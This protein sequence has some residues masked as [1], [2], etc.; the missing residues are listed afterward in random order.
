[1]RKRFGAAVKSEVV[2]QAINESSQAVISERGLRA[3]LPPKVE[4]ACRAG[5]GRP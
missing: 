2:E 1:M 5:A 4:L 3:A